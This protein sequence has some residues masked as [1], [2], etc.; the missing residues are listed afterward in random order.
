M[1]ILPRTQTRGLT[2]LPVY[3][4]RIKLIAPSIVGAETRAGGQSPRNRRKMRVHASFGPPPHR[5]TEG[6]SREQRIRLFG[7]ARAA[8][9]GDKSG[10]GTIKS[11]ASA[12]TRSLQNYGQN[13]ER[14]IRAAGAERRVSERR[15]RWQEA[16]GCAELA[17]NV[18]KR[19]SK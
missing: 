2:P 5:F 3:S 19:A 9:C 17:V 11:F 12:S 1:N 15:S 6:S 10:G 13:F 4:H 7:A 14:E 16:R 8:K 18:P